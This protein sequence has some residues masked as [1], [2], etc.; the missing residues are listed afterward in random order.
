MPLKHYFEQIK[1]FIFIYI[2]LTIMSSKNTKSGKMQIEDSNYSQRL[3]IEELQNKVK[4]LQI[5]LQNK[6]ILFLN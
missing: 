5:E 1:S 2:Y 3:G 4:E 6:G